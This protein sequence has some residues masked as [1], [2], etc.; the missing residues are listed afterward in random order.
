MERSHVREVV[1]LVQTAYPHTFT[2]LEFARRVE[3]VGGRDADRSLADWLAAVDDGRTAPGSPRVS[4][5][6]TTSPTP[7]A[8]AS[9][10]T[11]AAPNA[12]PTRSM[13]GC[14]TRSG[15]MPDPTPT[16]LRRPSDI[17]NPMSKTSVDVDR[18]IA[19]EAAEI[20]GTTTLRETIDASLREIVNAK[21]RL[22]LISLLG[23]DGRFDFDVAER[24]WGGD[25]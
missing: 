25:R 5:R 13:W 7:S 1:N 22:E 24:A 10:T 3:A 6:T 9:R 8:A 4:P 18:D 21:R 15:A 20:L 16:G 23:E 19:R 14:P 12:S 2:V 11:T 17:L